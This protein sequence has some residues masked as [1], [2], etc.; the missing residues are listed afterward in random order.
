MRITEAVENNYRIFYEGFCTKGVPVVI[1]VTGLEN[2]QP[3]SDWWLGNKA[4][5]N[6]RCLKFEA[7]ACITATRG[8]KDKD[9]GYINEDEYNFSRELVKDL[10]RSK[11]SEEGWKKVSWA[12]L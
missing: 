10:I 1:V 4:E 6:N 8:K 3:M 7:S 2:E 9:G 12:T 11:C 5:F